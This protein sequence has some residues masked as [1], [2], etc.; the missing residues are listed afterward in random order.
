LSNVF[1]QALFYHLAVIDAWQVI[2]DGLLLEGAN[3]RIQPFDDVLDAAIS[4]RT[5][6][7]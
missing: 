2:P 3:G 6:I 5:C 1:S 7:L 4:Y